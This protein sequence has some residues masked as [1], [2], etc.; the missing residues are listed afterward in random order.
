VR[1][2]AVIGSLRLKRMSPTAAHV[3][4]TDR[5]GRSLLGTAARFPRVAPFSGL[6]R[7]EFR[8]PVFAGT[9]SVSGVPSLC[10]L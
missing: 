5:A 3:R 7:R 9:L 8:Q 1:K 4:I 6:L 2:P 10:G